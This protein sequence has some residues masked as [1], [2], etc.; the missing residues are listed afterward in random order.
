M[1]TFYTQFVQVFVMQLS[2]SEWWIKPYKYKNNISLPF[3][4]LTE[5]K[6]PYEQCKKKK[7]YKS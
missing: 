2:A 3:P 1:V 4:L 6:F 5:Q 7:E